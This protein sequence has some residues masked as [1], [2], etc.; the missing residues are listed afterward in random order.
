VVI[1]E[2][3]SWGYR[4]Q[5]GA[6]EA[7]WNTTTTHPATAG[8]RTGNAVLGFG[9]SSVVTNIDTFA[10]TDDRPRAVYFT[11]SFDVADKAK[12]TRLVL[13]SVAN[14]GAVY[15]VNGVEVGRS[16]MPAG[17]V[18]HLTNAE[19]SRST[20]VANSSPVDIEVPTSLLV[21]GVNVV[22]AETHLNYRGTTDV[23]FDLKAT[24]TIGS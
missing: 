8:W 14:D 21:S 9:N 12:V 6:P 15:Y 19:T 1:D 18:T 20:A 24:L 5:P 16:N 10:K 3:S 7:D 2:R 4:Y 13:R 17:P 11:R 22:A 23:T